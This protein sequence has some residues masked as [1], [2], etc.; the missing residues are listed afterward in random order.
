M[1][2]ATTTSCRAIAVLVPASVISARRGPCARL[3]ATRSVTLGPGIRIKTVV[4]RRK[5]RY[6]S[7]SI[8]WRSD[9]DAAVDDEHL[10]RGVR[11]L[12]G[13]QVDRDRGDLLGRAEPA[14]RLPGDEIAARCFRVVEC[15]DPFVQ[16]RTLDGTWRYR[17]ATHAVAHIVGGDR[18]GQADHRG[19]AG[20][21]DEP[22]R[23][24]FEAR[25]HRRD[26]DDAAA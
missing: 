16:R 4:A 7:A 3:L 6:R 12:V 5:A 10:A 8:A 1:P 24:P 21:V 13:R 2:T 17:V 20:A 19:L 26:V 14:H 9:R 23:Q 15:C 25:A 22:V 18:L 11:A